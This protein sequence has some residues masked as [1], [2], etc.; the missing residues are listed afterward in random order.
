M[1]KNWWKVT[2][3]CA[4]A[5]FIAF[6]L[7]VRFLL[8]FAIV[9]TEEGYVTSDPTRALIVYGVV[10]AVIV[11]IGGLVFFRRMTRREIAMSACVLAALNVA[12]GLLVNGASG[13]VAAIYAYLSEWDTFLSVLFYRIGLGTWLS[14][15]IQWLLAPFIFVPFGRRT[16][17]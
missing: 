11:L 3:Y 7:E 4:V 1:R 12:C 13:T 17:R 14:A 6:E 5:S 2:L 8:N 16:G 15:W 10:F 9:T